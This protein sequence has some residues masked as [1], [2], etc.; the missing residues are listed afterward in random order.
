MDPPPPRPAVLWR[1]LAGLPLWLLHRL[2][3]AAG[4]ATWL[5]APAYRRRFEAHAALA[6]VAPA[7]R[8]RAI[9]EAGRVVAEMPRLWLRPA[10]E[11]I[12]DP[13]RWEG[14]ALI[15]RALTRPGGLILMTQHLGGFEVAAQAYAERFGAHRPMTV[16]YR[17][18]R[19]PWLRAFEDAARARPGLATAPATLAGVRQLSRAL[20][21]G[22]TVGLLPDQVPPWGLGVWAP[23]FGQ[24]AY[25]MTLAARLARQTGACVLLAWCERLPRGAGYVVRVVEPVHP[26]PTAP[27]A[28][29]SDRAASAAESR[30]AEPT[31]PPGADPGAEA[32]WLQAA[33]TA[34]NRSMEALIRQA[35][36]QYLWGYHRHKRPRGMPA[37]EV[38]PAI[39][40]PGGH[41]G[42][43]VAS[44]PP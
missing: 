38:V 3:A 9:A 34:I 18:A 14:E 44:S 22:Q 30:D 41:G 40:P 20:R 19:K 17:P 4:W 21:R 13:L 7:D 10:G 35:P 16:L 42:A 24:P 39:A 29:G 15:E 8:R 27:A 25:T 43:G 33:A 1:V 23:F 36:G 26:L 37:H 32:A 31:A 2:G 28:T 5:L 11:P 6:G 12:A